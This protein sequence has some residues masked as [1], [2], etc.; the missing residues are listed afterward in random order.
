MSEPIQNAE[1]APPVVVS[2]K[3]RPTR[4]AWGISLGVGIGAIAVVAILA[5][6]WFSVTYGVMNRYGSGSASAEVST[7]DAGTWFT[8]TDGKGT[9]TGYSNGS[10]SGD[11]M[12]S[13]TFA[14]IDLMAAGSVDGILITHTV[15]VYLGK[16]T[17]VTVEGKEWQPKRGGDSAVENL[18][19]GSYDEES[20]FDSRELTVEF[21]TV[22]KK[23]VA[24]SIDASGK[25][26]D[27]PYPWEQ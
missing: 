15:P 24:D 5:I 9:V 2:E 3:P 25:T 21:H 14:Y 11:G 6:A 22:G 23:L 18:F 27:G 13:G 8:V 4:F 16:K 12:V 7:V 26:L 10:G 1:T 19:G 17:K 20:P